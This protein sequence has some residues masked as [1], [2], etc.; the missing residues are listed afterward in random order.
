MT[1][2][3]ALRVTGV[4]AKTRKSLQAGFCRCPVQADAPPMGPKPLWCP[5]KKKF[6]C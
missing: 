1:S 2:D 3:I 5:P 4:R 6:G